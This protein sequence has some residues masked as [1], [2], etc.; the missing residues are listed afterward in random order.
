MMFDDVG[1]IAENPTIRDLGSLG[2]VLSPPPE[3]PVAGRPLVNLSLAFNYAT[4]NL[5]V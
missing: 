2:R 5:D 4:G 1:T 3:S